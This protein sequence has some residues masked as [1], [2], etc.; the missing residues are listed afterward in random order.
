MNVSDNET[1]PV[2]YQSHSCCPCS[3]PGREPGRTVW[4]RGDAS[5]GCRRGPELFPAPST[6]PSGAQGA[7]GPACGPDA[8]SARFLS[9]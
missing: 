9:G 7:A 2:S 8:Q 3:A 4:S 6:S 5:C 1:T